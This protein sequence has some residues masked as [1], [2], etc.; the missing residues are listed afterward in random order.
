M[1]STCA[2]RFEIFLTL[3]YNFL[4]I[5]VERNCKKVCALLVQW[6]RTETAS[7]YILM[8]STCA[9]S[10]FEE[11]SLLFSYKELV[12]FYSCKKVGLPESMHTGQNRSF[13]I[14]ASFQVF[15]TFFKENVFFLTFF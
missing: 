2:Q 3:L 11:I 7:F 13:Y 14:C 10:S 15:I 8:H 6:A 12:K 9:K 1:W 5:Q 4:M